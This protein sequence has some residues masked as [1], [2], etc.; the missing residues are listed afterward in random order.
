MNLGENIYTLRTKQNMS[1]GDLADALNVSRQSVSKWENNNA[2]PDLDKL[3]KMSSLFG[4]TLDQLVNSEKAMD[5]PAAHP[6]PEEV[7]RPQGI[8]TRKLLGVLLLVC[9]MLAFLVPTLL[10]GFLVGYFLGMPLAIMGCVLAF[11]QRE[12]FFRICWLLFA[13]LYP[14]LS[15]FGYNFVN[16]RILLRTSLPLLVLVVGL[17]IWTA[18]KFARKQLSSASKKIIAASL[19]LMLLV[20]ASFAAIIISYREESPLESQAAEVEM[21]TE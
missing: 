14:M 7:P 12:W 10:G 17:I 5:T 8:S 21:V 13:A 2:T 15:I 4:V 6:L 1:Q 16:F 18:V 11:S 3:I 19:A 20:T 9:G